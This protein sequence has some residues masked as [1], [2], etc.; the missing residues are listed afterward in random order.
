VLINEFTTRG[1]GNHPDLVEL[2]T[3][4][5]GDLGGM[6][7]YHGTPG[8]YDVKFVMPALEVG[9]G[10]FILVHFKPI[11]DP[12][13]VSEST[14]MRASGG[15]DSSD[16]AWDLWV[17]GGMG[18]AGNN[19]VL[20]LYQR[21]G[22]RCVDG[23]MYSNRTAQSDEAYRG[24]GSEDMRA[25]AEDLVRDGGWKAA[26]PRVT[27]EDGVSPEGST[28]TRSICR[29]SGS[30]DTDQRDD[31]H[32]VPLRRSSFGADNSDEVFTVLP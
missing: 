9:E 32:I 27:P 19:G 28:G 17:T 16:G 18:L 6:V 31:W 25:R 15:L 29:S 5:A 12:S 8:S 30:A 22:G 14:D 1:S 13:E 2:K 11:G 20:S 4:T 7:L 10:V 3:L 21:A 26:G 23:V 24:F